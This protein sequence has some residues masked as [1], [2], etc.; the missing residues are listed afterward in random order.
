MELTI[1]CHFSP[2]YHPLYS[3]FICTPFPYN[4]VT[5]LTGV[6]AVI[7]A[8]WECIVRLCRWGVIVSAKSTPPSARL[9]LMCS[10]FGTVSHQL[11]RCHA[12][13]NSGTKAVYC[14]FTN[15]CYTRFVRISR[16][17]STTTTLVPRSSGRPLGRKC[18]AH[19]RATKSG[20]ITSDS[21]DWLAVSSLH[22]LS[23]ARA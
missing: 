23:N 5:T 21:T 11:R 16:N 19:L 2:A 10:V 18:H 14:C 9:F 17:I 4:T 13:A 1:V 8:L 7:T 3:W 20:A 22:G 6:I 12:V 15:S